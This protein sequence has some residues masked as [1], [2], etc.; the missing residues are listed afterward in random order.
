MKS[1][2]VI[3]LASCSAF[4][5]IPHSGAKKDL[6]LDKE[7]FYTTENFLGSPY[8]ISK[9]PEN[10][11]PSKKGNDL[12]YNYNMPHPDKPDEPIKEV[13]PNGYNM[14]SKKLNSEGYT[15]P[16]KKVISFDEMN[17]DFYFKERQIPINDTKKK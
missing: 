5:Q 9:I 4:S 11:L 2:L 10:A 8:K 1:L 12:H 14:P 16:F 7:M 3:L 13:D 17:A 15:M 6:K